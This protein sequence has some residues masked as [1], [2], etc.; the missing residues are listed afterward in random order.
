MKTAV[1][2]SLERISVFGNAGSTPEITTIAGDDPEKSCDAL[3]ALERLAASLSPDGKT[4]NALLDLGSEIFSCGEKSGFRRGFRLAARLM[5]ESLGA[6]EG[7]ETG[8]KDD[9]S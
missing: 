6:P 4:E 7:P 2:D 8:G 1:I 5:V 9:G 3:D